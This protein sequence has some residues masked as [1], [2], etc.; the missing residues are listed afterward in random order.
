MDTSPSAHHRS[1]P[2]RSAPTPQVRA[3]RIA[4]FVVFALNGIAFAT[5]ASRLPTT[6]DDLG[7]SQAQLGLLLLCIAV[8]SVTALPTAGPLAARIG[9]M[10]LVRLATVVGLGGLAWA[11]FSASALHS[12]PLTVVGMVLMGVGIGGWDVGMN[13]EGAL[14]EQHLGRAI[15]PAF[16][17][18]FS[19]GTV[20]SA[21]LGAAMAWGEVP[22]WVH[23]LGVVAVS[24]V[25]LWWAS[26]R[27]L[28]E[29]APEGA[30]P[31]T[32][33]RAATSDRGPDQ[34]ATA[35]PAASAVPAP[36]S[37][38]G[39]WCEPRTLLIGVLV[40]SAAFT[41]GTA[42][43]WMAIALVDGYGAS[44]AVGAL[45]FAVFL[46]A[47]TAAR[48]GGQWALDRWGRVPVLRV[49]T[50][51]GAVGA[52]L[53]V[54]GEWLPLALVGAVLWGAGAA[55]GFPVGI[56]AAADDPQRAAV[57]VSV[58][59]TI[60][61]TAFLAG[62]PL[63]GFLG[64]HVGVLDALLVVALV[65]VPSLLVSRVASPTAGSPGQRRDEAARTP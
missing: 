32:T 24:L 31:T 7:L 22:V 5:W 38:L 61:Y 23:A 53:V 46:S 4:V 44:A 33:G 19:G 64:E 8:G 50:G 43:D 30:N 63:L 39:A 55:L 21:G 6:R 57:R 48:L 37:A 20:V 11:S 28:P 54:F 42:N 12:V 25:V 56:S 65:A 26:G 13:L 18:G 35:S 3:A 47:M 9:T 58:V 34:G 49:T 59:T 17:A 2:P 41:E 62:P 15:M 40:L 27:F 1:A 51:L 60:G 14:V 10:R 16:H 45:G 29:A 36:L 52:L